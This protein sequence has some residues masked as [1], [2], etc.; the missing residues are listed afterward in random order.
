MIRSLSC[1]TVLFTL[2]CGIA[3][4]ENENISIQLMHSTYKLSGKNSFGTAFLMGEPLPDN[5]KRGHIVLITAAHVLEKMSGNEAI[6]HLRRPTG[7]SYKR[8]PFSIPIRHE[9][10]ELWTKHPKVDVAAMRIAIPEEVKTTLLPTTLLANDDILSQLEIRPGDE[11]LVLGYPYGAEGNEAGFPIL[12]SGRIA[13]YPLLPTATTKTF[14]L[15]F[16]IFQGNSGGPVFFQ[17]DFRRI[18]GKPKTGDFRIVLG[19]VLRFNK[20]VTRI[21]Y[22]AILSPTTSTKGESHG[23]KNIKSRTLSEF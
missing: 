15:D 8:V 3:Y 21:I 1:L 17:Q 5:P 2:L 4:A 20:K 6:L 18:G 10:K 13:S 7:D 22:C 14:L 23:Q 9:D 11:L 12:R 16:E 19:L